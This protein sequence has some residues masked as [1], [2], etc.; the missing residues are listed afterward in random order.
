VQPVA[1]R[2]PQLPPRDAVVEGRQLGSLAVGVARA[3][4]SV[5]VTLLGPDGTG[6]DGRS[7]TIDGVAATPCGPG[8]YRARG[9]GVLVA[10][11]GRTLT[12]AVPARAPEASRLL[13]EVTRA[14][15]SAHTAVFDETLASSPRNSSTTRFRLVA[16][17]RLEYRTAGGPAAIVIGT[18]RWD[19]TAS[20]GPWVK[21][22]QSRLDVMEPYWREP[23]N[24]HLVAKDTLSFLD[25]RIPAWFRVTLDGKRPVRVQMTAAAHFMVDRYV[26]V[27]GPVTISPPPPSR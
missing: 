19:R 21:S 23:T 7:V 20:T 17:D 6:V 3:N 15:R 12:F 16:P 18:T 2:A 11:D 1:A 10:V 24:V 13:R 5:L 9:A 4:G 14:Y 8:C 25:R 27:D 26:G 22:T